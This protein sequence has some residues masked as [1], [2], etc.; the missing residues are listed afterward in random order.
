M[1]PNPMENPAASPTSPSVTEDGL[2]PVLQP[3]RTGWLDV[4]SGH[5]LYWE[6][7]GAPDGIPVVYLHG[8]PGGGC[9]PTYR[10][11]FDPARYRIILFDQRGAG[12]SRPYAGVM[13][14]TTAHLVS[15]IEAL[16][17]HLGVDAWLAFGGS[18]GSTL[19]LAYGQAFPE[20]TLGF[21]LRGVFLFTAR[22]VDWFLHGMGRLFP[23]AAS[24]F[25]E[26]LP[27]E[28]QGDLLASYYAR[29]TSPDPAV[30]GPAAQAW[31]AYEDACS[32]LL[33]REMRSGLGGGSLSMA[34]IEAHYML[35]AGFLA[36]DDQLLAGVD[37]IRH[38]PCEIVQGRYDVV[39]PAEA[40]HALHRAWPGSVLRMIADAGHSA[41]EPGTRAALVRASDAFARRSAGG[42]DAAAR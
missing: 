13:A 6:E 21:I 12:R 5:S 3:R 33:P 29:L 35:N 20:R 22:E 16:R 9:A 31:T 42:A 8:G 36:A 10:R 23:E 7:C 40:A 37:R 26:A 27:V 1:V 18:W 28:E 24:L 4:G 38:L 11:F 32:R 30:H 25:R 15:D 14:N 39:C 17:K 19:A 34:R 41:L 2:Y